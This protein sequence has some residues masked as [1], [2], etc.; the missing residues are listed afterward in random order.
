MSDINMPLAPEP[1]GQQDVDLP[2]NTTPTYTST[3]VFS[4]ND[5]TGTFGGLTQ[6]D[7]LPGETPVIDFSADPMVTKEG[8]DL[9]PIN[10]EFGYVVT[11]FIGAV[12]KTF[13]GNPEYE[14]GWAG[15]LKNEL[16]E[17]AG[18]VVADSPT[19]VFLTPARLGT[20][21]VGM[22]GESIKAS[23]EHYSVMQALLSDQDYSGDTDAL[24]P[25][26]DTLTIVGG[27]YDGWDLADAIAD[28][29][30][31]NGDDVADI[32]DVLAPNETTITENI[33][34]GDDYSVSVKDDGKVLYRW[35]NA[36][37]KPNDIRIESEIALPDEWK[38]DID[39]A[40][41]LQ[42]L[43][44]VS[45]AEL[46]VRHTITNNPNDQ[47]RPEDYENEAAT[48][49]LPT[50]EILPDG[51]WVST[52]DYYA[53][54]GT[55]YP[56]GTVLK[57]PALAALAVNSALYGTGAMSVDMLQGFTN[58]W[59]QTMDREPFEPVLNADGTDYEVGPRWRLKADKYGQDLPSVT[60]P[61]DPSLEPPAH[62][63]PG[64][65][66][67]GC[68]NPDRHQPDG[69]EDHFAAH[70]Q[71]GLAQR[72]GHGFGQRRELHRQL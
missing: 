32:K 8:V 65:V 6:G 18:L 45:Q 3:Y 63:G 38:A 36:I 35:G 21:L 64:E 52:D 23:T 2:L 34:V 57:D 25:L 33:A 31:V 7:V 40:T 22:G 20:W 69:L 42:P 41:G 11:D 54:D 59:Y 68:G 29:G 62:A 24:Y 9:Y 4:T 37:K 17:Q 53:G 60:I 50:Y 46:V 49:T 28:A 70:H 71:H 5:I 61:V 12:P 14:E 19:D 44:I 10:S 48:G 47:I 1:D 72:G 66:R 30:D 26:D 67:C 58:A 51:K 15:D 43:Y 56:A 13:D 55:F 27:T 39:D 16:G